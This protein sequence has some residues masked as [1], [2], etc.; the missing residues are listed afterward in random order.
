MRCA[1][2][3]GRARR[4]ARTDR[5]RWSARSRDPIMKTLTPLLLRHRGSA[6][7]LVHAAIVTLAYTLAFAL[8]F[9]FAIPPNMAMTLVLTLPLVLACRLSAYWAC[10]VFRGS[11]RYLNMR[12]VED[13]V[14]ASVLGS[15]LLLSA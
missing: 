11:W 10:G 5:R 8:R 4:R 3:C 2:R 13:I 7:V 1:R 12:D 6:A 15:A 14:R 9:D